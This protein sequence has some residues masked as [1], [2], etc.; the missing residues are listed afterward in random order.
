MTV[1]HRFATIRPLLRPVSQRALHPVLALALAVLLVSASGVGAQ[2]AQPAAQMT[3]DPHEQPHF[4]LEELFPEGQRFS[5]DIPSPQEFLGYEIGTHHTRHDQIVAYFRELARLSDRVSYQEIGRTVEHRVM[6]VITVTSPANHQRLDEIR[7]THLRALDADSGPVP[8]ADR[9]VIVH[10]GYGVHGNETSSSEVAM[11][12][13]YWLAASELDEVAGYLAE[14]VFHIE[15]VLNPDGRDRHTHWANMHKSDPFV[16]DPLDREHNEVWPGG[17]THHYWF[18]LNRDWLPLQAPESRARIDFHHQW[19]PNVVTDYHEMGTNSTYF[20]EPTKPEGSWNPLLPEELYTDI[21][22]RF[23]DYWAESLDELGSL[24]FTKE[25]FDNTYPGYGSTYPNFLGGL[26]LV[27]EQASARG[28]LQSSSHHGELSFGFA[29]RNQ[30]R[31]SLATVRASVE[32]KERLL[33]YQRDFYLGGLAEAGDFPVRGWVFGED[34]N[35]SLN[36]EFLDLLLRHRIEVY[37]VGA[38]T[39]VGGESYRAGGAW[40]V[41]VEQPGY[42]MVRSIFERTDSYADSVFYDASTWT[43]SLAYGIRHDELTGTLPLGSLVEDVPAPEGLGAVPRA[44][45]AYLL[46]WSDYYAPR[47]LQYLLARGV[48][49][50]ASLQPF[51]ASTNLGAYEYPAGSI[52]I[53]LQLQSVEPDELHALILEAEMRSGVPFQATETGYSLA[54]IDLGSGNVRPMTPPRPL[55]I[56]GSGVSA[57]EAGQIWHL[58]DT[59]VDLPIT[60]V[61]RDQ[62]GRINFD[63][64][65]H[66]VLASGNYNFLSEGQ[67]EDLRRWL[68]RGGTLVAIRSA[69][70]WA[71]GQGFAPRIAADREGAGDLLPD[72]WEDVPLGR[73]DWAD[74]GVISG[75]QQIG[76]SIY[77]A[78]VDITHPLGFGLHRR[79]LPVWRDHSFLYPPASNPYSTVVQLTEDPHLSG[80]ISERNLERLR[81]TASV[82]IDQVGGGS[83]LL[84]LD[85]PNFRGYWY[86]TNRLFLNALFHGS[87]SSVP[88]APW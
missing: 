29:I 77:E 56:V 13:A 60:K 79:T 31:T 35:A 58:L 33:E 75:A 6:P 88:G 9:P 66:V 55:M 14:G 69:A 84:F 83:V 54:G 61:D 72:D 34:R 43:M 45:Y 25:V 7:Q 17:R 32:E 16:A 53:P 15:P 22:L 47:A 49:A 78:D 26:G 44:S 19:R 4:T 27:F 21:T 86:G 23:A 85:N 71:V 1:L 42:R 63:E 57:N 38:D 48:R 87:Y 51:T 76:G 11:L 70:N 50:E 73:R 74:A 67:R 65:T 12:Q 39:E 80:Y 46:D 64:Y 81:G 18:D 68:Q 5:A 37:E 28:H 40:V 36:R 82:L 41:P 10:L 62:V 20:F 3:P 8:A 30:L 59:R 24:Y 2:Q 52:S